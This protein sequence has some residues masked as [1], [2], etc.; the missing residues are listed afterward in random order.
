MF[1]LKK[2]SE[3]KILVVAHRGVWGGNIP[4]NTLPAFETA[5]RQGA[6]MIELDID[7]TSD[8]KLVI[9]HPKME[10]VF[11]GFGDSINRYPWSFVKELRYLNYD[12][13]PTQFGLLTLDEALEAL[14]GQCFINAD[15]FWL[16]PREIS[17]TI[18]RH[19]MADQI[20]VKTSVKNTYLDIIEQF[21]PD[22]QYMAIVRSE[23]EIEMAR[24][25][26]IRYVG[27]EVLF[28][29]D[30][31]ELASVD[32]IRRQHQKGLLIWCN[33]IVYNYRTVLAGG[34]SDDRAAGGDMEG[35]YGWIAD[36]GFDF[37]QTDR[38]LEA[39]QFL[40]ETGRMTRRSAC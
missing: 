16:R 13:T 27:S 1:D 38:V 33:S 34:H 2:S 35:S 19:N 21:C 5:L 18:R 3:E 32:F 12:A 39:V 4:C 11:L 22:M 10:R 26:K 24:Q 14:K 36:R 31:A 25:R 30:D 40:R 9:F 17:E 6:D 28:D 29:R 20:L 37:I 8:G 7:A 23:E 15:K